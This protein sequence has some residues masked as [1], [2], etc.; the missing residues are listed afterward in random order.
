MSDSSL[1]AS[2]NSSA[3]RRDFLKSSTA[4]VGGAMV[5]SLSIARSAYAAG[6]DEIKIALIGCGGRGTGAANQALRTHG[7]VKLV[8]LADVFGD[9]LQ[10]S[11]KQLSAQSEI[12]DRI[13]V[14]QERQF[15]GFDAYQKALEAGPDLVI[16]ATPPGFRPIHFEAAVKAGKH[17]FMEKPVATDAPG[18]RRVLAAA[19]ESKK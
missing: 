15:V 11:L 13:D 19:E 1:P 17:V 6:D 7:K 5:G 2:G 8:A 16:L 9:R 10:G 18:V 12:K 3:S 4:I 14:P